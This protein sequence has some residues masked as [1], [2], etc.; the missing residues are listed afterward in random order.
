MCVSRR[1][2]TQLDKMYALG[3]PP[4]YEPDPARSVAAI[5][6]REGR[7]AA[8]VAYDLMLDG[9]G[10]N[11]LYM[12]FANYA[13][14]NLDAVREQLLHPAAVVGLSDG[15]AHVGTVCDVSFPTTLLQW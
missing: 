2:I 6:E 15:G 13:D 7:A 14:G 10:R 11:L 1:I 5:A 4:V 3:N 9:T 8:E 12:P